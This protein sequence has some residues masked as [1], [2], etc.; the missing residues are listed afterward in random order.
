MSKISFIILHYIVISDTIECINS[1]LDNVG[2]NEYTII[3]VDN[4]SPNATGLELKNLYKNERRVKV[5]LNNLNLG[6]AKGNNI[7]FEI[8]KKE[9]F[10]EFIIMINNDTIIKQRN[11]VDIV[12]SKYYQYG[13]AI[14][15]PNIISTAN[16]KNQNPYVTLKYSKKSLLLILI[17]LN[18]IL[19][20]NYFSL[21]YIVLKT[22][23]RKK[24]LD[25]KSSYDSTKEYTNVGL[26]GSCLIFSPKYIQRFDGLED[27]TFLYVEE[28]I[29]FYRIITNSLISLYSNEIEIF[30]KE[31]SSTNAVHKKKKL[32]RRFKYKNEIKSIFVLLNLIH[33]NQ[34]SR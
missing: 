3:V 5:V 15:G 8:A 18:G 20:L 21:D 34:K 27:R 23:K 17:K 22:R 32:S 31:D 24:K 11:F 26:H 9:L 10:S 12:I 2:Y 14:M 33:K 16:N 19:F 29:L 7:G 28:D 30:H 1:I 6:F 25:S 13:Y 4:A